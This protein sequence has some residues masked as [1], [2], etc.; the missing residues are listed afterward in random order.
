[1]IITKNPIWLFMS[2]LFIIYACKPGEKKDKRK[3]EVQAEMQA[4]IN[5]LKSATYFKDN[6]IRTYLKE[7]LEA[8]YTNRNYKMAWMTSDKIL[9]QSDSLLQAISMAT[10]E[11]LEPENYEFQEIQNLRNE[12]FSAKKSKRDTL[13]LRKLVQLDFKMTASYLTYASHLLGGR[14]DPA[15]LDTLWIT[16]SRKKDL[17]AH[18][19]EAIRQNRI[20]T[21]LQELSPIVSQYKQM[22]RQLAH[23]QQIAQAGGWPS[24]AQVKN[25]TKGASGEAV[26]TLWKRLGVIGDLDTTKVRTPVFDDNMEQAVKRFQ[27]RHGIKPDGK[28]NSETVA[29][30]NKPVK[31]ITQL[32]ELN[33]ERI[34]WSPDSLGDTYFLVNVPEYALKVFANGKKEQEMRVIVGKDYAST[35]VFSDT[36]EYIVFSPDWTVPTSIAKNEIL[37]ILQRNPDY[38]IN[39]NMAVYE[40]WNESDTTALDPYATDWLQ[41]T[42]ETFNYRIVQKPGPQNPLGKVKFMLPNNLFI[43]LHDTPNH[44]LFKREERDLSHGCIRLEKPVDLAMYLLNWNQEQVIEKLDQPE[45]IVQNLPKKWPVQIVYRTAWV[46]EKGILNFRDDIYGHDKKQLN[47]IAR[48]ENQLSKL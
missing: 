23:Y 43:Y 1:M 35:P 30:L 29:W 14:I 26:Q 7:E 47:A 9:P 40:T 36:L 48:K 10:A 22:Q 31:E 25:V 42:P 17:S 13:N 32:L 18:L 37:P 15:K 33:L 5:R 12:I 6:A 41:F 28:L 20:Y 8:F 44:N 39:Q 2:L 11:G 24:I 27:Q 45:P 3:E 4:Q 21:S 34:R 38:L 46:D 16:Y 19:E